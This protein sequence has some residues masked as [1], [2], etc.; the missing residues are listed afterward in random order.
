MKT[1]VVTGAASGIGLD[2]AKRSA[3]D[4]WRVVLLD[5]DAASVVAAA[6]QLECEHV[7]ADITDPDCL[8]ATFAAIGDRHGGING[9][10]NSA[11]LTRTGPTAELSIADWRSVV[12]VNLSGTFYACR[13]AVAHMPP[14]S[15]IVNLTSIAAVRALPGRAAYTATKFGVLGL[16]RVLA[17][18]W[19]PLQIR[20]N[21]VGPAWTRTPFFDAL[22]DEGK[23]D[24]LDL[25]RRVPMG[26]LAEVSDVSAAVAFLLSSESGFVTGQTL[27]VDGGY[28]WNG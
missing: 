27:Y 22:V 17:V 18:E 24:E 20:V 21:A 11:G 2:V 25:I 10:V 16:T 6:A 26:R 15:S 19:A 5:H 23:V 3:R 14:E 13:M 12:D 9:L 4:G 7:V 1:L 28:T 8:A